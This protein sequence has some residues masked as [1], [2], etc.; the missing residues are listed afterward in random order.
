[1][2]RRTLR[3][4]PLLLFFS[5]HSPGG[6]GA[7]QDAALLCT[8][9]AQ[10]R[11]SHKRSIVPNTYGSFQH[12]KPTAVPRAV[13]NVCYDQED[14]NSSMMTQ[15]CSVGL[16]IAAPGCTQT[17]AQCAAVK[18]LIRE[19]MIQT[20]KCPSHPT[21]PSAQRISHLPAPCS[22]YL[23][24]QRISWQ[25]HHSAAELWISYLAAAPG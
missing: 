7:E 11:V 17:P 3:L 2:L 24:A 19:N 1:M 22:P 14:K 13:Q 25:N 21:A 10:P 5:Q 18:E 9:T 12:P 16:Q 23:R 4:N 8:D 6:L 15:G 20:V